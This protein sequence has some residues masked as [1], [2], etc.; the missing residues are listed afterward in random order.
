M[1]HTVYSPFS[2]LTP[3]QR[4]SH[5]LFMHSDDGTPYIFEL[6]IIFC[7]IQQQFLYYAVGA[8]EFIKIDWVCASDREIERG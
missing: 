8:L 3:I 1:F 2:H 7:A 6:K 5:S 4:S